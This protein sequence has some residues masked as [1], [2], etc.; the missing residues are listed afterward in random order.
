MR[1]AAL[2]ARIALRGSRAALRIAARIALR[3]AARLA[4]WNLSMCRPPLPLRQCMRRGAFSCGRGACPAGACP[5]PCRLTAP[6]WC[7]QGGLSGWSAAD[8]A[9][10]EAARGACFFSR[11]PILPLVCF[12]APIPPAPFP[13]GEGGEII[14]FL[15]KGL[16]PLHPRA[17]PGRHLQPQQKRYPAGGLP[18]LP[19]AD[20]AFSLFS[21]PHPPAPLPHW[22]RGAGGWGLQSKLKAG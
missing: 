9:V 22:G 1:R 12:V 4:A 14:V 5:P 16:R 17:E 18:C 20:H 13:S 8:R 6:L 3:I 21:F 11:L 2:P 15:C 19:P 7:P 10:P